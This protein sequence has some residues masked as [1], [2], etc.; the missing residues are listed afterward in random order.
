[1][2]RDPRVR[3]SATFSA[4]C[5][6]SEQRRNRASPSFHSPVFLSNERGVL[7]TVKFATAAPVVVN[8]I[9]GSAVRLPMTVMVVSPAMVVGVLSGCGA[10]VGV[11][12]PVGQVPARYGRVS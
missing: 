11:W 10:G 12:V 9:S 1:M 6:Q 3:V 8:L 7:A 5:R 2:T 4:G